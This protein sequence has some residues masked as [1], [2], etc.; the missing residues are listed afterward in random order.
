MRPI[1]FALALALNLPGLPALATSL[2]DADTVLARTNPQAATDSAAAPAPAAELLS[3]L[4]GFRAGMAMMPPEQAAE[5]WLRLFD[6]AIELGPMADNYDHLDPHL[7]APVGPASV[8]ASLPPPR[9]WPALRIKTKQR[10]QQRADDPK[11][12][13]LRLLS[14]LLLRDRK[15]AEATLAQLE[16]LYQGKRRSERDMGRAAIGELRSTVLD[17]YGS[18]KEIAAG[19]TLRMEEVSRHPY[20]N[21][22]NVP[23][24]VGLVGEAEAEAL[25]RQALR[26][27]LQLSVAEGEATRA[28]ARRLASEQIAEL[29]KPQWGLVDDLQAT[30]LY[31]ALHARFVGI[32][33]R[34][35]EV[36]EEVEDYDYERSEADGWYFVASVVAGRQLEA[37]RA[38]AALSGKGALSVPSAAIRALHEG[39]HNN[40]LFR[41]LDELLGRRPELDAWR[42]Y[43]EQ[44][45]YSGHADAALQRI[46]TLLE[47]PTLPSFQRNALRAHRIDALLA[48]DRVEAALAGL[49]QR[50]HELAAADQGSASERA[51]LMLRKAAVLRVLGQPDPALTALAASLAATLPQLQ[52]S[53]DDFRLGAHL[54]KLA[55]ELR[56]QGRLGEA[57]QLALAVLA[58][59]KPSHQVEFAAL[60]PDALDRFALIELVA[61]F[62]AAQRPDDVLKLLDGARGWAARDLGELLAEKDAL[63]VP[64]GTLAARALAASGHSAAALA[65][66]EAL[67]D[68]QPGHDA[69]Y[70]L[71]LELLGERAIPALDTRYGRDPFE[72]RPLIWKGIALQKAG[73]VQESE[74]AIRA[75]IAI[76]PSDGEQGRDDRMRAYAVLAEL[77]RGKGELDAAATYEGAVAAIRLSEQADELHA[78]GLL[79]RAFATYR[80]ALDRF[81]DAY[82]IQSRLALQ[83]S[84]RGQH[85]QALQH[86]RRAYELMPD[87]F[88]RVESHCFG[89]ESVFQDPAAQGV[90]DD[91]FGRLVKAA[92]AKPQTH[93]ML[94][95]LRIEQGRYQE[96][97]DR[98]RMAVALDGDYLN[99]WK[100][101]HELGQKTY[102]PAAER[103]IARLK[104]L[105][106]DPRMRHVRYELDRVGDLAGLWKALETAQAAR[107]GERNRGPLRPLQASA[108]A[109]AET[110][111]RMPD[112]MRQQLEQFL[113]MGEQPQGRGGAWPAP[114]VVLARH[115]LMLPIARL[116]GAG[117]HDQFGDFGDTFD[118]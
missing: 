37:E 108:A 86:Y 28:L 2:L 19:F 53:S 34:E 59:P 64:L 57:Q 49:D 77:L 105:E 117:G 113:A 112:A 46:E 63:G 75:A 31:E 32:A 96:A 69:G 15:A 27:P 110:M 99:A 92:P 81:A 76:D 52:R 3:D 24:L 51:E 103:D 42:L 6:R 104:L 54:G 9:A 68:V 21:Q 114:S 47:Q 116:L 66:V 10:A 95:Y 70:A 80:E 13:G 106:L 12:I 41:F 83:L 79:Q 87:S 115:A 73:R 17:L 85:E 29:R 40:A 35:A 67:L 97:L 38:L 23:D 102:L 58:R 72:E 4:L 18:E 89:C 90:A 107:A 55:S 25:L 82:C 36:E 43:L 5:T 61:I 26:R 44:A 50:L 84:K 65:T 14:E 100:K 98:L 94:A 7:R 88:G 78:L 93:Y 39:G 101:L 71:L 20:D 60:Q 111:A 33:S 16:Q 118:H 22:L 1:V 8:L 74:A 11:A 62:D 48:A 45:A 91:V 30:A 56:R 109:Y